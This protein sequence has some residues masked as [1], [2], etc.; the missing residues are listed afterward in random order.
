MLCS[1]LDSRMLKIQQY[2]CKTHGFHTFTY[3]GPYVWNSHPQDVRYCST[4]PSFKTKLETFLFSQYFIPAGSPSHDGDVKVYVL[5]IK[6][7][8]LAHSF[9]SVL[10]SI[11]LLWPFHLYFIP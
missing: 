10:V 7:T 6:P 5:D 4:L 8:E 1:S 11:S 9:Y 3:F 2:K